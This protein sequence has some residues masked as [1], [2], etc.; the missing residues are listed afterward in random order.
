MRFA[1]YF[2]ISSLFILT[3][4]VYS[5]EVPVLKKWLLNKLYIISSSKTDFE[6]K[7]EHLNF[8]FL[9][10][11]IKIYNVSVKPKANSISQIIT[12]V[13]IDMLEVNLSPSALISGRFEIGKILLKHPVTS[14]FIKNT[15]DDSN[16]ATTNTATAAPFQIPWNE[17]MSLPVRKIII[18]DA[19]IQTKVDPAQMFLKVSGFGI[20]LEKSSSAAKL[21]IFSPKTL[22]KKFNQE[23]SLIEIGLATRIILESQAAE[24][25]AI[26]ISSGDNF[27]MARG[28]ARGS[29]LNLNWSNLSVRTIAHFDIEDVVK[30]IKNFIPQFQAPKASGVVN[31]ELLGTTKKNA[32]PLG[33]FHLDA[34]NIKIEQFNIGNIYSKL[35][36]NNNIITSDLLRITTSAGTINIK[37]ATVEHGNTSKFSGRIATESLELKQTLANLGIPT[38][39]L[40]FDTFLKAACEGVYL[41]QVKMECA[42]EVGG[43]NLKISTPDKK[44]IVAIKDIKIITRFLLDNKTMTFP[45]GELAMGESKGRASGFLNF[46]EGFSFDFE[47]DSLDFKDIQ[48][49]ADLKYE[50]SVAL[51][52]NTQGNGSTA[53]VSTNV[54]TNGFWF[55]DFGIGTSQFDLRFEKSKL[56]FDNLS[57]QF[58]NSQYAGQ[59]ELNLDN[60]HI[61]SKIDFSKLSLAELAKVFARKL[62]L[63]LKA[64]GHGTA[65]LE[66]SGPVDLAKLDYTL[67]SQFT[68]GFV[69]GETFNSFSFNVTGKNGNVVAD[70]V[71]LK[72]GDGT[73]TLKGDVSNQGIMSVFIKGQDLH[74]SDFEHVKSFMPG[75]DGRVQADISLQDKIT[76]PKLNLRG[77][78]TQATLSQEK[79][80]DSNFSIDISPES[81][82]YTVQLLNNQVNAALVRPRRGKSLFSFKLDAQNWDFSSFLSQISGSE[83]KKDYETSL[84]IK[85]ALV[86]ET[87]N[88]WDSKGEIR[89]P[90]LYVRHGTSQMEN[91]SEVL[92]K[93]DEGL[94]NIENLKFIGDNTEISVEGQRNKKNNLNLNINGQLDLGLFT[95][96]TPFF[97]DMRGSL[98]INSQVAGTTERPEFLGTALINKA[99]FKLKEFPHA[100]EDINSDL[101]FSQSK[102]VVNSLKGTVG[103][104][105]LTASGS[106][107]MKGPQNV[108]IE[109]AGE[110][111]KTTLNIPEG[112]ITKGSGEFSISGNWWPYTLHANFNIDSGQYTKN[113]GDQE[114]SVLMKRSVF[115]PST[116]QQKTASSIDF[117]LNVNILK[118][119]AIRNSLLEADV[120][121]NLHIKGDPEH[122]ILSGEINTLPNAKFYFRETPFILSVGKAKFNNPNENN[123]NVYAV[124]AA[125]VRDWDI[126]LLYQGNLDKHDIKL[127]SAPALPEKSIISLLA[128]GI[129]DDNLEKNK[130]SDQL[131]LQ[132]YQA[133]SVILQQNPLI[134]DFKKKAGVTVR[135]SQTVD[136]TR[137]TVMP[138]FVA[139]KQWTPKFSTSLGRTFGEKSSRDVSIE[140]RFNRNFSVLGSYEQR[141]YDQF[142]VST[143]TSSTS[144][145]SSSSVQATTTTTD[146]LGLNLQYQVD[147]R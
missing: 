103:G 67:K 134:Q 19:E 132:G 127:S 33:S 131:A 5:R 133:G 30:K 101:I 46:D 125:R 32:A 56:Y 53:K 16:N 130:S 10:P 115:L 51:K 61:Q 105:N 80:E 22:I 114:N 135:L 4:I 141:D 97:K 79:I 108:P 55:E 92:V 119:V 48:S 68:N 52:G 60:G 121:G 77:L 28:V 18:K 73:F 36:F 118:S 45:T 24:V 43:K 27:V 69:L 136:D 112:L 91:K 40:H 6:V 9:P 35:N 146:I 113:F 41:P 85:S 78:I 98:K 139:E 15:Q 62:K 122:T 54:K 87:G 109:I 70:S 145:T 90:R 59:M 99:T 58:D 93:F 49:L 107:T 144:A 116:V 128:L 88:F 38:T 76:D 64:E 137:N 26:K 143:T 17:I 31:F 50:G 110:L 104:G 138:K 65:Q 84:T 20:N 147:F 96:L 124:G 2:V 95:F 71:S 29:V 74:L 39:P 120:K 129:T 81:E 8:T 123:P 25:S 12:P 7:A 11:G 86:S 142:S 83:F 102:I 37:D 13:K 14:V 106:V 42:G 57:G 72:K 1:K 66:L 111:Q 63:D 94:V 21:E 47:T 117:D 75:V 100:F 3:G 89:I 140:Y 23:Q 82:K 44:T 34:Q 126:N